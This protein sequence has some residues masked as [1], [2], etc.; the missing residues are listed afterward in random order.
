MAYKTVTEYQQLYFKLN[1]INKNTSGN[2]YF[3]NDSDLIQNE[4]IQMQ[5]H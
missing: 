5:S 1:T 2:I 3:L 4:T